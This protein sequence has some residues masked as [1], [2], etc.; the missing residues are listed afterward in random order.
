MAY[1]NPYQPYANQSPYFQPQYQQAQKM[2]ITKVNG[3]NGAE[4]LQLAPNSSVLLL[5][6]TAP[7]IWLKVTDGAGYP[8]ITPYS[9][10]PYQPEPEVDTRSLEARIAKLEELMNNKNVE[11]VNDVKPNNA[12][13]K[14]KQGSTTDGT[15]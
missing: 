14:R 15:D 2:E 12:S 13:T 3:K 7:I 6:E 8:T 9:I 4:A 5:D 11:V 1:Y 10:T